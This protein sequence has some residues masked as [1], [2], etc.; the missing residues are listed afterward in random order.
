MGWKVEGTY[1]EN[2]NCD[3]VCPCTVTSLLAQSTGERCQV[4]VNYHIQH[5]EVDGVDVSGRNVSLIVDAPKNMLAGGWRVGLI[6]DAAASPDQADKL[7]AFF[8]GRLGGPPAVF[9]PL[10]G[11]I[12]GID[13]QPID[14]RDDG[15]SHHV[16][17][18]RD[19]AI[20]IEDYVPH[21]AS[22]PTRLTG[23]THP[24]SSTLTIARVNSSRIRGFGMEFNN[25]GKSAF[26][27]PFRWSS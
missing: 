19:V 18:G 16:Q 15:R 11:E 22:E 7:A 6:V 20:D 10:I 27:A 26:S 5:G 24:V 25:A 14:Y 8:G 3:W 1:F 23:V 13:R 9:L 21:G 2:C 17:I 4:M 12:L